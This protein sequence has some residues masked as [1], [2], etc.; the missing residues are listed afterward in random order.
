ML[1]SR[2]DSLFHETVSFS[3]PLSHPS[4]LFQ[5]THIFQANSWSFQP[6][7]AFALAGKMIVT[8][9]LI[10]SLDYSFPLSNPGEWMD[11]TSKCPQMEYKS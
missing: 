6:F 3:M 4:S 5:I 11:Q 2:L 10:L 8:K 7:L 9:Y 1:C